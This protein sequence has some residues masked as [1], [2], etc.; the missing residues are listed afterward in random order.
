MKA[1]G[2]IAWLSRRAFVGANIGA[3]ALAAVPVRAFA[4]AA[5]PQTVTIE[6]F[7]P[8]GES[9]GEVQLQKVVRTDAEWHQIL[10]PLQFAIARQGGTETPYTGATWNNHAKGLYRCICCDT[11]LFDS[12]VKF[13]SHTGWPSFSRALSSDNIVRSR[14]DSANMHRIAIACTLC[15]AHLG[16]V[17][18]DGPKP[19][20]L[21]YCM[22]SASLRF[23]PSPAQE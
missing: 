19:T 18:H 4:V 6:K 16:H 21:R 11:A 7:S 10:T 3:L 5:I 20:G 2:D 12:F 1:S 15:D 22:N 17:F 9:L 14:D 13:D 8:A 23:V